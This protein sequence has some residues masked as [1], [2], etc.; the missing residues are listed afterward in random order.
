MLESSFKTS[1]Y[2]HRITEFCVGIQIVVHR[3][4]RYVHFYT[5]DIT[6]LLHTYL[7]QRVASFNAR[8][9]NRYPM[10]MVL[11]GAGRKIEYQPE[12]VYDSY[13]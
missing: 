8:I 7:G 12:I 4:A 5:L 6:I 13:H 2:F 11:A 1:I 10:K 9:L 3:M